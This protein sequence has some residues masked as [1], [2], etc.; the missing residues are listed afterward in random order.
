MVGFE[1]VEGEAAQPGEDA[2][3][4]ANAPAIFTQGDV[5]AVVRGILDLPVGADRLGSAGGGEWRAGEVKG[6][7]GGAAQR[8]VLAL[9]VKTSRSTRMTAPRGGQ[10]VS[11]NAS[12][13][14]KTATATFL[15]VASAVAATGGP[16]R[17]RAGR[18]I[19]A[20]R[21]RV[22]WLSLT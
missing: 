1:N 22:G 16:E 15:A 7:L 11:V 5:T 6:G 9:R 3:V 14:S 17:R 10:S 13:G 18:D 19:L 2:G 12:A 21:C 8:P 4:G 20:F